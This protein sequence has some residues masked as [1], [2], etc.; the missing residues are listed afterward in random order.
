MAL[1]KSLEVLPELTCWEV[2]DIRNLEEIRDKAANYLEPIMNIADQNDDGV[3]SVKDLDAIKIGLSELVH[4]FTEVF[5][6]I[7]YNGD[8]VLD[9]PGDGPGFQFIFFQDY[10]LSHFD[11]NQDG[12]ID[13]KDWYIKIQAD[14]MR[15]LFPHIVTQIING[16]DRDGNG[17]VEQNELVNFIKNLFNVIDT[18]GDG[19]ITEDDVFNTLRDRGINSTKVEAM[20]SYF[21]EIREWSK[22]VIMT[23]ADQILKELDT[24]KDKTLTRE[25]LYETRDDLFAGR[26]FYKFR[27]GKFPHHPDILNP[28]H[29]STRYENLG[30]N[31][32]AVAASIL[33]DAACSCNVPSAEP[34]LADDDC[35]GLACMGM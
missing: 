26:R 18:H 29:S 7:D 24:N 21:N 10:A 6:L 20:Q 30:Y 31:F 12:K 2:K 33:G 16:I 19:Y 17:K 5:K 27:I 3:I 4:L 34:A 14:R 32:L 25:E 11:V 23:T 13:V 1:D 35:I 15:G 8:G 28:R 9:V 22:E